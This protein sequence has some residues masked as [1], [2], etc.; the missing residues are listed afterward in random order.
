M[1]RVQFCVLVCIFRL[2]FKLVMKMAQLNEQQK[3]FIYQGFQMYT[4]ICLSAKF[5][6]QRK[7]INILLNIFIHITLHN[8][9]RYIN[10]KLIFTTI[11]KKHYNRELK[12][13]TGNYNIW[14]QWQIC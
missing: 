10:R 5:I 9:I 14:P 6:S 11:K 3:L 7:K 1:Q 13:Y 12:K 4:F 2:N 8:T